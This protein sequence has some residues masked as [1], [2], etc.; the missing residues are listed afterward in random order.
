MARPGF[1]RDSKGRRST[2]SYRLIGAVEIKAYF[3]FFPGHSENG[4]ETSMEN[5]L[6][7][8]RQMAI[9]HQRI[10]L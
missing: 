3:N 10:R 5:S 1:K 7:A 8:Q 2:T 4:K 9:S 6:M